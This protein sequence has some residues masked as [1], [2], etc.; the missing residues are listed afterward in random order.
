[1]ETFEEI[2]SFVDNEL[3]DHS[4]ICRIKSLI[5]ENSAIKTEYMRQTS[6][7]E[8]LKKRCCRANAPDHLV[9]NIKQQLYCFIDASSKNKISSRNRN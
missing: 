1:M 3:K 7:K 9:T 5:E 4:I 2:T 6:I 8:L